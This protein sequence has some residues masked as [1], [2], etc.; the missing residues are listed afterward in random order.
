MTDTAIDPPRRRMW[1]RNAV[2]DVIALREG[3][4]TEIETLM[5]KCSLAVG[6]KLA[7]AADTFPKEN[8]S[9]Y[10]PRP[11][12]H[13]WVE[14]R[15]KCSPRWA[16]NLINAY[17]KFGARTEVRA[18]PWKVV[19]AL[20]PASVPQEAVDQVLAK[21]ED[22]TVTEAQAKQIVKAAKAIRAANTQQ[23]HAARIERLAAISAN[24]A[25]LPTGR[26]YP[27]LYADPPWKFE[28]DSFFGPQRAVASHYPTMTVD[29]ISGLQVAEIATPDAVLFLWVTATHLPE[30]F[31]VIEAWGFRYVNNIVWVK[32]GDIGLGNYVRNQHEILLIAT[33]GEMLMPLPANRP[34][35]VIRAARREHSRKPDEAYELIERMY[36]DLP[37][38]ELFARE[39]HEGWDA[40]GNEVPMEDVA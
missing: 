1:Q 13:E 22:G 26:V 30:A 7:E 27:V 8:E 28:T 24:S 37:R 32:E 31:K 33:R 20:S 2:S 36:S 10:A 38:I 40:W 34:R 9:K 23:N 19:L 4:A 25:A 29:E 15:F 18:L 17:E 3:L 35:S 12:W 14:Q 5:R 11:G 21:V 6:K 39:R 16:T